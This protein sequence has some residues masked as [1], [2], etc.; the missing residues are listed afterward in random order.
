[1]SLLYT[2]VG[3]FTIANPIGNLPIYLSF[4]D[5]ERRRDQVIP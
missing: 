3:V 2:A 1:L 5:G 4:T